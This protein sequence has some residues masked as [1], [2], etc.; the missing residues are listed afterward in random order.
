MKS[1]RSDYDFKSHI[2]D[3]YV[4]PNSNPCYSPGSH[5]HSA[6]PGF[7]FCA[8]DPKTFFRTVLYNA[9]SV[10]HSSHTATETTSI[11]PGDAARDAYSGP[12][13]RVMSV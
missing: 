10:D 5:P 1:A 8:R 11:S 12:C 13:N 7:E 3:V 9:L 4:Y 2:I 6:A